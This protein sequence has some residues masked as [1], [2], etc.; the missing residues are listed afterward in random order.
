MY[1]KTIKALLIIGILIITTVNIQAQ[2]IGFFNNNIINPYSINPAKAGIDG[3]K[4]FL[5]QRNQWVGIQGAPIFS[6]LTAEWRLGESK[7]AV[8][9]NISHNTASILSNT[10]SYITYAH[11]FRLSENQ[12]LSFGLSAG[13]RNNSI[14]FDQVYALDTDDPLVF[15]YNQTGTSFDASFGMNYKFKALEI[16]FASLQIFANKTVFS[17]SFEQKE[18]EYN[19]VRHFFASVGYKFKAGDNF[20]ITPI[21]QARNI[22]GQNIQPEAIV[23]FDYKDFIWTAVHYNYKRSYAFTVGVAVSEMFVIGYSAEFSANEFQG[24][25][26]GTHEIVFGIKFGS[27]FQTNINKKKIKELEKTTRGYDER[28]EYLKRENE[29]LRKEMKLQEDALEELTDGASYKEIKKVLKKEEQIADSSQTPNKEVKQPEK[30][31]QIKKNTSSQ[32]KIIKNVKDNG[33]EVAFYK[34]RS[35][36]LYPSY[37]PLKNIAKILKDNPTAKITI[38][39]YTDETGISDGKNTLAKDRAEAVKAYLIKQGVSADKITSKGM[40]KSTSNNKNTLN[41]KKINRIVDVKVEM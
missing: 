10:S 9:L 5:Q 33:D 1:S 28:L 11:H 2:Q 18:L 22:Q 4:I 12:Y 34:G 32:S 21:F 20:N 38:S 39:A 27:S 24:Y 3:S 13:I 19:F 14:L 6:Q 35:V 25:S 7:S 29:R 8:G 17:S 40:G 30:V 31:E 26:N 36:L 15:D 23:K 16:Q 41:D 37:K